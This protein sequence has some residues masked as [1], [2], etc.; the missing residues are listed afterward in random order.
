[1]IKYIC[2]KEKEKD[3][4][5]MKIWLDSEKK[6]PRGYLQMNNIQET[7]HFIS[8][9]SPNVFW[10]EDL[11]LIDIGDMPDIEAFFFWLE[12]TYPKINFN[13]NI[14]TEKSFDIWEFFMM[15]SETFKNWEVTFIVLC[16]N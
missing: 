16:D 15:F 5:S 14:H 8:N 2:N 7:Q 9:L 10:D 1:M 13:I 4:I 11:E 6:A 12:R 3:M